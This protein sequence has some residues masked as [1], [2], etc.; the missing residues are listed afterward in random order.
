MSAGLNMDLHYLD[1]LYCY[2]EALHAYGVQVDV[3]GTDAPLDDYR[4]VIAPTLYM[5]KPGV[6][7]RLSAFTEQ[8]GTLV[9]SIYSGMADENDN[10]TQS[11]Y[12]GELRKLCGL[13]I[14]EFDSLPS[15]ECN[16]FTWDGQRYTS[17]LMFALSHPEGAQT[18]AGYET[19]FYQGMP[20]LS[21]HHTGKG[22]V[23]YFGTRSE[24]AFY[25]AFTK[26]LCTEQ[27]LLSQDAKE[28]PE[29]LELS[30]REK[31]GVN[32][33]FFLNHL[34]EENHTARENSI[35]LTDQLAGT[36]MLS[37]RK[38]CGGET[39]TLPPYGVELLRQG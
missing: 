3:I 9:L 7:D 24:K 23:Y 14:E 6:S 35:C 36:S 13:W 28:L 5:V 10:V 20:V 39:L 32:Y 16:H 34:G 37:G 33:L 29:G 4:L 2:Y 21:V 31:D 11:G 15:G 30:I 12:P 25:H 18:L 1:E 38:Y 27:G 17:E 22:Q 26:K 19:D 8:G